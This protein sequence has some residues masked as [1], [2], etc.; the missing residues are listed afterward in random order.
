M[1]V[2]ILAVWKSGAAFV[3]VDPSYPDE[4]IQ[5]ILQDTKAKIV[6]SNKKY[7]TR[8]DRYDIMT[9]ALDCSLLNQFMNNNQMAFNSDPNTTKNNL[10]YVI[11]TSGTTGQPKG[12]MIEHAT[13][14]ALRND[15]IHRFFGADYIQNLPKA[16]LFLANYG[17]DLSVEQIVLSILGSNMLIIISNTFTVDETFY[18]YLNAERMTYISMTPSQ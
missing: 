4:R 1:I 18:A 7:M 15:V 16:I 10:A 8:F 9:I 11:Y 13:V 14:V 5:F 12:V 17:F 6:I 2:S 3:P